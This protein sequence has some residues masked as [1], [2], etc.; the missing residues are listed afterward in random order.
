M[1]IIINKYIYIY[2]Y[3]ICPEAQLSRERKQLRYPYFINWIEL[4]NQI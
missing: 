3:S 1:I 2:I 4:I